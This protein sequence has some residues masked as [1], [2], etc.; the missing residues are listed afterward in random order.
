MKGL[1]KYIF[2]LLFAVSFQQVNAQFRL[3]MEMIVTDNGKKLPGA[4]IKVFKNGSLVETLLTDAKGLADIPMDPNGN[5]SIEI[6]GNKGLIKKK[7]SVNTN[8]VPAEGAKGDVFFPAEVKLFKKLEGMDVSILEKPIGK[9][10]YD[11]DYGEFDADP[12]YTKTIQKQFQQ[13]EKDFLAQQ[14]AAA[15][16]TLN[17]QKKYDAAI[18]IADKAFS[19]ENWEKA[20]EQYKIAEKVNPDPLET[21]PSFQLAELQTK[22][23]KIKADNKRYDNAISKADAAVVAKEYEIAIAEYKRASG[24]KPKEEY[25]KGK[26]KEVQNI[27]VNAVKVDQSY[28]AAIEKGDNALKINDM[29]TAKTAFQEA[30]AL[31]SD[32]V[33]PKNKIAEIDDILAKQGAKKAEYDNAIKEADDTLA[34]KEYEK[35]KAAYTKAKG[36]KPGEKYPVDQ[37]ARVEALMVSAA[38]VEQNYLLAIEKGDQALGSKSYAEAKTAFEN[39][40]QLKSDEEYPKNKIKEI[41]ELI[42]KNEAQDKNYKTKITEGDKALAAKNYEGAKT[43][44]QGAKGIKPTESYPQQKLTEIDGILANLA[45]AE[46]SYKVAIAKGDKAIIAKDFETAKAAFTEAISLKA[47][48]QYPKDKL[49]EIQTIVL[50]NKKNEEK[51]NT[52][53]QNGDDAI[54][55]K[56]LAKAKEFFTEALSVKQTKVTRKVKSLRLKR[57]LR[58]K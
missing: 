50:S 18:K 8:N 3:I 5:Y 28:L 40:S 41:N 26:V 42:A 58:I 23:I 31:K 57:Q 35:S 24:Y 33:Y 44:Y 37:I 46:E 56:D 45:K 43:A 22:L 55:N 21:Y 49:A 53:I 29:K 2:L 15:A 32:E 6:G 38:K 17:A 14:A 52:A 11:P 47:K 34:A 10:V 48:E 7:L 19:D 51:Y 54:A 1:L 25:P 12:R 9:I 27:L 4:Q 36:L 16:N 20:S 39:A 30:V 13:L